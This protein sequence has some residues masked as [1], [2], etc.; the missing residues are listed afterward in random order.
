MYQENL[1]REREK[2]RIAEAARAARKAQSEA[3]RIVLP[4]LAQV[5]ADRADPGKTPHDPDRAL[6]GGWR[7]EDMAEQR[8][9][10]AVKRGKRKR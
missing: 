5:K 8:R 6:F 9:E 3:E 2:F 7:L 10:A 4:D 1:R